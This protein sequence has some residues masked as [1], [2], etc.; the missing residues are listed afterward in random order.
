MVAA[1]ATEGGKADAEAD[2]TL[3]AGATEPAEVV[4]AE[5]RWELLRFGAST[6]SLILLSE[7]A[8]AGATEAERDSDRTKGAQS[9]DEP[10]SSSLLNAARCRLGST[11]LLA[12]IAES[13]WGIQRRHA[14]H[15]VSFRCIRFT[16]VVALP[17]C[18]HLSNTSSPGPGSSHVYSRSRSSRPGPRRGTVEAAEAK[19]PDRCA[20]GAGGG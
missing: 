16:R 20:P 7:A 13:N 3:A 10:R 6:M 14:G 4:P 17:F 18:T 19:E 1:A 12:W 11:D 9:E 5:A 15:T 2:A 8:A